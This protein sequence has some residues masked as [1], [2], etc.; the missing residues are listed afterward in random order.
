MP[1]KPLE[2][3]EA[4]GRICQRQING[5]KSH[6]SGLDP[7]QILQKIRCES[8]LAIIIKTNPQAQVK[9]FRLLVASLTRKKHEKQWLLIIAV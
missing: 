2:A 9:L 6:G 4:R 1:F 7:K 3:C 8:Y 5:Q